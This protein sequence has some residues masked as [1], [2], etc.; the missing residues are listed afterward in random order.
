MPCGLQIGGGIRP[1]NAALYLEAGASHVIVTSHMFDAD[2]TFNPGKLAA[3]V[4]ETGV[5]RLVLDLSCKRV[6]EGWTVAMN[7]WQT[8]T[9]LQVDHST[10]D[11]LAAY[12]DE[13]LIHAVEVEGKCEG[14]DEELVRFLGQWGGK[15]M[16]YAGGARTMQDLWLV[17]RASEGRV[18]VTVGSALDMFGGSGMRY[19]D[20]VA[21]NARSSAS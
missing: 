7:R 1:D 14:I 6:A 20:C 2:G 3:L 11:H 9:N 12:C 13:F 4:A 16:T 18:D 5:G 10:L 21:F 15:P 17:Q 19:A 8:L